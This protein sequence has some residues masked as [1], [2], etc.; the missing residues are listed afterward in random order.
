MNARMKDL[1]E[2]ML[3][4]S[5]KYVF[6]LTPSKFKIDNMQRIIRDVV[7]QIIAFSGVLYSALEAVT[8]LPFKVQVFERQFRLQPLTCYGFLLVSPSVRHSKRC[9]C[10]SLTKSSLVRSY[11]TGCNSFPGM[12]TNL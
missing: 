7:G 1:L 8:T 10:L 4:L 5:D 2:E 3:V 12:P 11:G 6:A 9:S